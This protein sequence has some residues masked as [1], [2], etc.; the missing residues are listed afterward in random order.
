MLNYCIINN[1]KFKFCAKLLLEFEAI[2]PTKPSKTMDKKKRKN[3]V[4]ADIGQILIITV[5]V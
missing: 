1:S 4:D 5:F 3:F 2:K